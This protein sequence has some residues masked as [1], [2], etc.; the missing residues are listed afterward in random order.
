MEANKCFIKLNIFSLPTYNV[1]AAKENGT[2]YASCRYF[3]FWYL[4][5]S[6][7][8][9]IYMHD[10]KF[11]T[12]IFYACCKLCAALKIILVLDHELARSC[13]LV[14]PLCTLWNVKSWI[15]LLQ[16]AMSFLGH[17][18]ICF[19]TFPGI[20]ERKLE[21]QWKKNIRNVLS[22]RLICQM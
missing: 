21:E 8:V 6:I 12:L 7:N 17:W 19:F 10:C 13:I 18:Y 16:L 20:L 3:I 15:E 22:N 2:F 5:M 1:V 11:L 14:W 9:P 4:Q